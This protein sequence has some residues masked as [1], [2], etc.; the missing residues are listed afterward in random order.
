MKT[1][2]RS[3][4][5][6]TKFEEFFATSYK[7]DVFEILETYP[8]NRSLTV[9]YH[10][11]ELFDPDLADL[12]IEKPEEVIEASQIAIKNIDPIA[13]DADLNIRFQNVTNIIPLKILLSKYI[14]SF[15]SADGI[16]RK[17]D[18]I[19]PRIETAVF[20]CRGCMR[21]HEVE[22]TSDR[23]I[24][25][26]S[27]C[28]ECGGRSFR[29]LQEESHYID[30]Q[31]ARMQEPLEN[32]SGGTEPKQMLMILE[33]DLVDELN[34][35]DKVRVT[36][37][38]KT[39]REERTGKFKNY[40][41]VNH[42]EPLEQ[43]FEELH[44][45]EE[46]EE[47]IIELS[48]DPHIYEKIIKSTAPSIKGYRDVKEAIAM[49]L[50][51]GAAKQLEDETRLRGDI[52]ILIV[53]DPGIGKSQI[54][55][56]V[57]KLAPRSIYTS[58]KGTTGA[59]LTA[60]AVRDELGGWSLEAGALVL[61][62]QGNV[63]VDELDK[64]RSEDRSALHEALEQQTVSIA[65]AGIMATL[66]SR[67]SVLA[68]ANPK[69]GRFDRFK[70]LAEQIELPPPILSRFDLIFVV[71]DKPSRKGDSEL[72][73]HIL[74]IHKS[75]SIEY[76]IEPELLRKYIAYARKN[77]NP[78]LTDEATDVLKSFYVDTRN[79][80]SNTEEN[81]PVPITARQLEALIRLAE[82]CAK[83]KL[84]DVVEKEDAKKAVRLQ[85]ACL[86]D[87]GVDPETGEPD[88]S[89]VEG[90]TP[91]SQRDKMGV[92]VE[93]VKL[94]EEE[95]AGRAPINVIIENMESKH[96][97]SEETTKKLVDSL[98]QRGVLYEPSSGYY[99]RVDKD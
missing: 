52:H 3:Q 47:K 56:Y 45:S 33:D 81:A 78:I 79:S 1:T 43:E 14:G 28:S 4:T 37:T 57:S 5:S 83:M 55:K 40:I 20:E 77:V 60:A 73:Q 53:G 76:E 85:M 70:V 17:T 62:D 86:K 96:N 50:F 16:V 15:V 6:I 27:L 91:K 58:G 99:E 93:E 25:E 13:K 2:N 90:N 71:E 95:Y 69:F 38:L 36:G 87:V 30:T 48:K 8:D 19:R 54:L 10:A 63:C 41:Y 39:F 22:Q 21:L 68:A 44:L 84:K 42:I 32:L 75:N 24:L 80:S 34:P 82:A 18:E 67:C 66:N 74:Q 65:K 29:L 46:D 64:M 26:P 89:L 7:D 59:G 61:G 31:T 88:I 98:R 92:I 49:Q 94:I 11:L 12:L 35:G 9:D 23:T 72:A 51:G 97:V